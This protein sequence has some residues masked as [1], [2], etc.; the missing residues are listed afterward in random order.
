MIA[1]PKGT[2]IVS[3]LYPF[4]TDIVIIYIIIIVPIIPDGWENGYASTD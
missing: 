1:Y 3:F 4:N 2:K